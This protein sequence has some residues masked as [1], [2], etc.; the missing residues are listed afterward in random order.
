LP[1]GETETFG[2]MDPIRKQAMSHR[3]NAFAKLVA[4]CIA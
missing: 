2:E 4:D 3:A 1:D